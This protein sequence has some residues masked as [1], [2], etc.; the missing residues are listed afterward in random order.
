MDDAT[1]LLEIEA[2]KQVKGTYALAVVSSSD[3]NRIVCTK[4]SSPMVLGLSQGQNFVASDV[5]ALLEHTRKVTFLK[6]SSA[7]VC[8]PGGFGTQD[9]TF[10]HDDAHRALSE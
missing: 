5:P 7:F 6:E 3:P 2:I 9:E 10:E 1:A 8:L 4:D